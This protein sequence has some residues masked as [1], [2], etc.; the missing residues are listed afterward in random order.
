VALAGK[1]ALGAGAGFGAGEGRG[2]KGGGGGGGRGGG[3]LHLKVCDP[4]FK[5]FHFIFFVLKSGEETAKSFLQLCY[6][7][8]KIFDSCFRTGNTVAERTVTA[9]L[10]LP[11]PHEVD[12]WPGVPARAGGVL[13]LGAEAGDAGVES[14][15][16]LAKLAMASLVKL[17]DGAGK[18]DISGVTELTSFLSTLHFQF[19]SS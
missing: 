3:G 17:A 14:S 16:V 7:S 12:A 18:G 6:F 5:N 2:R 9:E 8:F 13:T 10:A 15:A 1:V 4:L 11:K 19:L